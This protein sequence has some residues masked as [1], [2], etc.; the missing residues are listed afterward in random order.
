M[1]KNDYL[2]AGLQFFARQEYKSAET[3]LKK[4]LVLDPDFDLAINALCEVYNR[5]G[6]LDQALILAQKLCQL[7]PDDPM[8]HAAISRIYMQKGMI[9]E[10]EEELA[11]SNNLSAQKG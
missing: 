3:E 1:T 7:T 5:A 2:R 11:I 10:A 8:A 6:D 9:P 4:A